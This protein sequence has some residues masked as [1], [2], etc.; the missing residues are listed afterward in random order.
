MLMRTERIKVEPLS[1]GAIMSS[2]AQGIYRIPRFQRI[3]VWERSRIQSLLDSMYREYPIGTIFLWK[4]PAK[5]NHMLRSVDYLQQPPIETDQSY[6][7]ILDGQQRLTSLYVVVNG[8]TIGVERYTKIVADLENNE[9]EKYFQYRTADNRRWISVQNLL[10]DNS[11]ELYDSLPPE[12]RQRFQEIRQRL[13]SYPFSVVSV[14][15][16]ELDDAIEIFERINQQSKRLTRYDLIAASVLTDQ[17]DL[18]QRS[19]NDIIEPLAQSFGAIPETNEPQALALN[20]RGRTEHTTQMSLETGEVQA[21]WERTVTCLKLAVDFVQANLGVKRA[22]FIPYSSMLAVLGYYFYYGQTNAVKSNFHRDQLEKWFWRTAF[23]ERYSGASQTR[24][25]EDAEQIRKLIDK[26]EPFDLDRMPVSLDEKALLDAR[27][28]NTTSA[29]RNGILCMLYLMRPLHFI[30]KSE[31]MLQGEYFS[32]F[33]LAERH[34]IFPIAFLQDRDVPHQRVHRIPNFCFIPAELNQQ[35]S[36][37]APSQYFAELRNQHGDSGDFEKIMNTHLIPVDE[38]SGIWTDDLDR[39]LRQRAHLMMLEIRKLCG[40][41]VRLPEEQRNPVI[42]AVEVALRDTIHNHLSAAYGLNYWK[43]AIPGDVRANSDDRIEKMLTS[44]PGIERSQY[45]NPRARLDQCD[46]S[47]YTRIINNAQN[48]PHFSATFRSK[49]DTERMLN[50]FR[51]Y[52]NAV[53][54]NHPADTLLD[55]QGNAA[56]VFLSRAL[57]LD[58]SRFGIS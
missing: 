25:T 9:A 57:K 41:T 53:K 58:L 47:D 56:V 45:D 8:L 23:A 15:S 28:S 13:S 26:D 4:A 17:F 32:K 37:Q 38:D 27:M 34:H 22:D 7:F 44:I 11:F 30:N 6:T 19:Q 50:D 48:W 51:R 54:H 12:Y 31:I 46:V 3:F 55:L 5:Y 16:M 20:I 36:N 43:S 1:F 52:R 18:R 42:D 21:A 10:K 33:T 49:P 24:M 2:M 29:I 35:I 39:F 40:L 14:S